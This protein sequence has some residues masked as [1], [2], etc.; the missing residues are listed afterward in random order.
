VRDL[1]VL[2]LHLL[3]T[4]ARL[5]GPGGAR[6]VI[7]ESLLVKQQLLILNRSLK[8]SPNLRFSDRLVAG[9]CALL[10]R[11]RRLIRS[12]IVLNPSTLLSLHRA[13][14]QRKYRRLFSS[15]VSTKPGPKGP[16][17]EVIAAVVDMKRR[18]PTWGCPRIAQHEGQSVESR[19][20]PMRIGRAAHRLGA[21]RDGPMHASHRGFCRASR[22][23][24]W[25]GAVPIVQS[26]NCG[27]TKACSFR[28]ACRAIGNSPPTGAAAGGFG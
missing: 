10:M 7:A 17:Q 6:S 22:R 28:C 2:F 25:R 3:A 8:R 1:A 11:P 12:A 26:C 13:L 23:R 27:T 14:T 21:R 15:K 5:A 24:G 18:N 20:V 9:V 16:T 19:S 4:V